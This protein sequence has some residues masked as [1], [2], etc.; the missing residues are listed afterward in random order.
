LTMP[1]FRGGKQTKKAEKGMFERGVSGRKVPPSRGWEKGEKRKKLEKG[2]KDRISGDAKG[3][4]CSP[5]KKEAGGGVGG[6]T[7]ETH[8]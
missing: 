1:L 3:V 5:R 4:E 2:T 7:A 8:R 6:A